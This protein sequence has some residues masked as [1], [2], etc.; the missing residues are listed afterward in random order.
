M[1]QR[2]RGDSGKKSSGT[3][4]SRQWKRGIPDEKGPGQI[5]KGAEREK[6]DGAK[7]KKGG[8]EGGGGRKK[9]KGERGRR[10]SRLQVLLNSSTPT[11]HKNN[12]PGSLHR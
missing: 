2:S 5:H 11:H 8:E 7:K 9:R 6:V 3:L 10:G 1:F 4:D 12:G